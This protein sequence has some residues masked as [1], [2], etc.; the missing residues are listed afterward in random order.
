MLTRLPLV[1]EV[2]VPYRDGVSKRQV[3]EFLEMEID[4]M[5]FGDLH[6][7]FLAHEQWRN[8][9]YS[10]HVMP[11][12]DGGFLFSFNTASSE[13]FATAYIPPMVGKPTGHQMT[14]IEE[15]LERDNTRI[16]AARAAFSIDRDADTKKVM[17]TPPEAIL[18]SDREQR[19]ARLKELLSAVVVADG[20]VWWRVPRPMLA[21]R[22][23]DEAVS[24]AIHVAGRH[25]PGAWC[26]KGHILVP[27]TAA[28]ILPLAAEAMGLRCNLDF[29]VDQIGD[30]HPDE[31]AFDADEWL[32]ER[33]IM[34]AVPG[35]RRHVGKLSDDGIAAWMALRDRVEGD[36]NT[37][38]GREF[39]TT[40][41][42]LSEE[43]DDKKVK[44][45]HVEW[46]KLFAPM[47]S[48][49][50]PVDTLQALNFQG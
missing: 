27:V 40:Y 8:S 20:R 16:L 42:T 46:R 50:P 25:E 13:A 41:S 10:S 36:L 43:I 14:F 18:A 21:I 32:L 34:D 48:Q 28:G 37:P 33:E 35:V 12:V 7:G 19:L 30:V 5:A 47:L 23:H 26:S 38:F 3:V 6:L 9:R 44:F 2:A 45:K 24:A 39:E 29:S 22:F 31:I 1:Y 49:E 11:K 17:L 15:M 4:E